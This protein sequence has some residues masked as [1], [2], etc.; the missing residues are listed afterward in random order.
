MC[1]QSCSFCPPTQRRPSFLT[2]DQFQRIL[3]QVAPLAS[4]MY[5]HVRGEPLLHPQLARFLDLAHQAGVGVHLVTNGTLLARVGQA[6]VGHPA[7]RQISISL[8]SFE[9]DEANHEEQDSYWAPIVRFVRDVEAAGGT[10]VTLRFWR[11]SASGLRQ[12]VETEFAQRGPRTFLHTDQPFD[13]PSL[14]NP[15]V[16]ETGYCLALRDQVAVLVDGTVVPCCLDAEG[17]MALGNLFTDDIQD[18][19][20]GPGARALYE[21]FSR[22]RCVE[23][24]CQ[25]CSFR[26]RFDGCLGGKSPL[27]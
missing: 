14:A 8:H 22:R 12:V 10:T 3:T 23:A 6:L 4:L 2:E 19:L 13:W 26:Q 9:G 5:F 15:W 16:G 21:G 27:P 18:I 25:H 1:N 7:L 20:D 11:G 24:L 17:E